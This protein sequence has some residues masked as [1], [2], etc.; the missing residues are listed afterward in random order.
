MQMGKDVEE[1]VLEL[2]RNAPER[3]SGSY[4]RAKLKTYKRLF[5]SVPVVKIS[6]WSIGKEAVTVCLRI[7]SWHSHGQNEE[8]HRDVFQII[9]V[10]IEYS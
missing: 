10:F 7:K 5:L 1:A 8:N 4:N 2:E 3:R 6:N 9:Y